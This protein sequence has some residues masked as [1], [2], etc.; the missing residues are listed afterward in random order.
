MQP[1]QPPTRSTRIMLATLIGIAAM[2]QMFRTMAALVAPGLQND[3]A[4]STEQL[5][6]FAGAFHLSFALAQIPVGVALD[7]Y[8]ARR[9]I[10][11]AFLLTVAGAI[12]CSVA[13][14]FAVLVLGQ[15]L[16]GVGCA[17]AFVGTL[18]FVAKAYPEDRFA[19]LSAVVLSLSGLGLLVTGT[20][21]AWVVEQW[22]WRGAFGLTSAMAAANLVA[23]LIFVR[24]AKC[25]EQVSKGNVLSETVAVVREPHTKGILILALFGYSSYLT[26]RGL[27]ATPL[28][29]DRYGFTLTDIG[30]VLLV[31]SVA[32]LIGPPLFGF[33]KAEAQ[34]RRYLL[35]ASIVASAAA[36]LILAFVSNWVV[37]ATM[38][39]VLGALTGF[40][41]LQFA[42]VKAAYGSAVVGRAFG[43]LNTATFLGVAL[44]QLVTGWAAA[45]AD[46]ISLD[47]F[48]AVFAVIAAA[49][50][51]ATFAFLA[52]PWPAFEDMKGRQKGRVASSRRRASVAR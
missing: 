48:T 49:C 34:S 46:V 32:A 40:T 7:V 14:N 52:L 9:T 20:P 44:M 24:D 47:Q 51:L 1:L 4:L 28:F 43:V 11:A 25:S 12:L 21:L 30:N 10:A 8:G 36:F 27:W 37:D 18:F 22:T 31:S 26:L 35:M 23:V 45:A 50:L 16:I 15:L 39:V 42:D 41:V 38:C 6:A 2:S 19:R 13:G 29:A 33:A 5:G 17:P 3:L